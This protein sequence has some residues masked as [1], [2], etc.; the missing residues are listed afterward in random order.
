MATG[1]T[2]YREG[3]RLY[4]P[5][6][7]FCTV[8]RIADGELYVRLGDGG[9]KRLDAA[10]QYMICNR[11]SL[12]QMSPPKP[13]PYAAFGE[14]LFSAFLD[15]DVERARELVE[16]TLLPLL[17]D[18]KAATSGEYPFDLL[19]R[20]KNPGTGNCH[21]YVV[22]LLSS[23]RGSTRGRRLQGESDLPCVY[24]GQSCI[25]VEERFEQHLGG[26]KSSYIV[27]EYGFALLPRLFEPYHSMTRWMAEE[28]ESALAKALHLIGC[29]VFGGH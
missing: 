15:G 23:A 9:L 11:P 7:G 16:A 6:V 5:R 24:V 4:T 25:P 20:A 2:A 12:F 13:R 19:A 28:A 1:D 18:K 26:Y 8:E 29:T 3:D 21:L 14:A 17:Q 22:L 27:R 10:G